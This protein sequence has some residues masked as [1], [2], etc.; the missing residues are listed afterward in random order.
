MQNLCKILNSNNVKI[1][2][3]DKI[4]MTLTIIVKFFE[5]LNVHGTEKV[6]K[7]RNYLKKTVE[8]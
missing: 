3:V 7:T 5:K 2:L 6:G 1:P 8:L 4:F